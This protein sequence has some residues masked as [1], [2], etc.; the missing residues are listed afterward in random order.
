MAGGRI[1][2]TIERLLDEAA[3]FAAAGDWPAVRE[4]A[5]RVIR[6]DPANVDANGF[7]DAANRRPW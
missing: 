6:L 3:D 4:R 1:Q 5:E 7:L 2:Q